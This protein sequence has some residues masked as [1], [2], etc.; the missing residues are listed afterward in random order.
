VG[1]SLS[2]A[3]MSW[4]RLQPTL[5]PPHIHVICIQRVSAP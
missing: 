1:R 5:S 4:L 2:D 3:V